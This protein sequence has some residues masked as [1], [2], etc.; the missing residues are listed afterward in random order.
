MNTFLTLILPQLIL[1]KLSSEE[2][3][4]YKSPYKTIKSRKAV[5]QFPRDLPMDGEP[6]DV[7]EAYSNYNQKLQQ[8]E[9]P[10]LLIYATPGSLITSKDV[11]WCK[12]NL[13][14]LITVDFG[15]GLHYIQEDNPHLIGAELA[16]WYQEL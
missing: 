16:K 7:H 10:K 5:R 2:K 6:K 8:S 15:E 3:D 1:R 13:K 14:N 11:D 4:H 12:E 9:L